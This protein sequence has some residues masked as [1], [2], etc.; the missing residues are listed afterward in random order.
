[1]AR[2]GVKKAAKKVPGK[3]RREADGKTGPAIPAP[4]ESHQ[5]PAVR[6]RMYRQGLGDCFLL[7]F[8]VGGDEA[9]MLIDCG[10]LGAVTTGVTMASVVAD[11]R[12]T[13]GDHL[14]RARCHSRAQGPR[15]GVRQPA[16][17]VR[18][19]GRGSGLAGVD[20][21][22]EGPAGEEDREGQ[23]GSRRP[24]WSRPPRRLP[25]PA[26]APPPRPSGS[27]C[28]MSSALAVIRR[29][30]QALPRPSTT[31]CP[32]CAPSWHP[33]PTISSRATVP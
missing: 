25:R 1:M 11:I 26:R 19:D 27:P 2:S 33:A 16:G 13:T 5:L 22:P 30:A 18:R 15:V 23:E 20:R 9:H 7:T 31:P 29:Q 14:E 8:D 24:P 28:A 12:S 17:G 6:V 10:T 3:R 21:E 32:S 4:G